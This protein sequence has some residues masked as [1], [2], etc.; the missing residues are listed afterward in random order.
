MKSESWTHVVQRLYFCKILPP[1]LWEVWGSIAKQSIVQS[2]DQ[3]QALLR[4][5]A[6]SPFSTMHLLCVLWDQFKLDRIRLHHLSF[7]HN[8]CWN[9]HWECIQNE[10]HLVGLLFEMIADEREFNNCIFNYSW[11]D[12]IWLSEIWKKMILLKGWAHIQWSPYYSRAQ[13]GLETLNQLHT[14]S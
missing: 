13:L 5:G 3:G 2:L 14:G 6:V 8:I 9:Y 1:S 12:H 11:L 4:S 10:I 7:Q